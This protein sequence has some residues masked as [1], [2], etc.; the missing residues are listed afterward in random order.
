MALPTF[1]AVHHAVPWLLL[2]ASPPAVQQAT[3]ISIFWPLGPQQQTYSSG[4]R[5]LNAGTDR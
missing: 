1:A 5:R 2:T 3:D 4:M